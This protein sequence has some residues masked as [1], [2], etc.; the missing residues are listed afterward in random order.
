MSILTKP[1]FNNENE[2]NLFI[3]EK[4]LNVSLCRNLQNTIKIEIKMVNRAISG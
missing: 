1:L 2:Y 3:F 4:Y